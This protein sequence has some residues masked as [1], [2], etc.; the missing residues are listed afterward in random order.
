[1]NFF[2]KSHN[3]RWAALTLL[4]A[5][6]A[7]EPGTRPSLASVEVLTSKGDLPAAYLQIKSLLQEDPRSAAARHLLATVLLRQREAEGAEA[8]FRRALEY[9]HPPDAVWPELATAMLAQGKANALINEGSKVTLK[10]AVAWNRLRL[11]LAKAQGMLGQRDAARAAVAKILVDAPQLTDAVLLEAM[12]AADR[13]SP[14]ELLAKLKPITGEG[15]KSPEAFNY[16]G[17]V[18]LIGKNDIAGARTAYQRSLALDPRSVS[19]YTALVALAF[20]EGDAKA[21]ETLLGEMRKVLP[22]HPQTTLFEAQL[23]FLK[24]NLDGARDAAVRVLRFAPEHLPALQLAGAIELQRGGLLQAEN[25]LSK[26][27]TLAPSLPLAR[28]L[29]AQIYLRGGQPAKGLALIGDMAAQNNARPEVLETAAEIQL[30]LGRHAAAEELYA[31]AAKLKP[32]DAALRTALAMTRLS[33]DESAVLSSLESIAAEDRGVVADLALINLR[34]RRQEFDAALVAI[35]GMG[36]KNPSSP[37]VDNLRGRVLLGKHDEAGARKS[38]ESAL[39]KDPKF[40]T[41]AASLAQMD[42]RAGN[43][44]E[45]IKR[46]EAVIKADPRSVPAAISLGELRLRT[47]TKRQ[48]VTPL[49]ETAVKSNPLDSTAHLALV[50]HL[51]AANDPHG[52][53]AA[54]Q[55]GTTALP[56]APELQEALGRAQLAAGEV[57]QALSSFNKV[58]SM[59]PQSAAPLVHITNAYLANRMPAQAVS[60]AA[61]AVDLEPHSTD[62]RRA[63]V[64]T[65]IAAKKPE[66]ALDKALELQRRLPGF[67]YGFLLEGDLAAE[68]RKWS[69]AEAAYRK[70]LDKQQVGKLPVRLHLMLLYSKQNAA[71]DAFA[72]QWLQRHPNDVAFLAYLGDAATSRGDAITALQHYET[73]LKLRPDDPMALNNVAY[74]RVTNR[75]PGGR[76]LAERACEL[77]PET[78]PFLDTLAFALAEEGQLDKAITVARQAADLSP[79]QPAFRLNLARYLVR[80][81]DRVAA[82]KELDQLA[83]LGSKFAGGQATVAKLRAS[84]K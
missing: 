24:G 21:V 71:A 56:Q 79:V 18:L 78:A 62:A 63:L 49:L 46:F 54:A 55:R 12:L 65:S 9:G 30:S 73:W 32:N 35:D 28:R 76:E 20:H 3:V 22:Q 15:G 41:A 26:A 5:L 17:N 80:K 81:G 34:L 43:T 64:T 19:S 58:A 75:K 7:C 42:A 27:L 47:G 53:V 57:Q 37:Q 45:A 39:S 83:A 59:M 66:V 52:A 84:L 33:Q 25:Y 48:D 10:D 50:A 51:L 13:S 36:K 31:R 40:F 70:G 72:A 16:L 38:F 4:L 69:E 82:T 23:A 29:L 77:Q 67:A 68:Q 6:C 61:R 2:P 8:E 44:A 11:Q 14:D 60:S 74:M 1:M